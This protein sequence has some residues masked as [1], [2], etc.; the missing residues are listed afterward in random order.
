MNELLKA[1]IYVSL[2]G[3]LLYD[4]TSRLHTYAAVYMHENYYSPVHVSILCKSLYVSIVTS[5][6]YGL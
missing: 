4:D 1:K 2:V 6:Q 5:I 3:L